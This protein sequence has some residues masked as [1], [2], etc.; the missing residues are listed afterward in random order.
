[1]ETFKVI[2]HTDGDDKC[3]RN[4]VNYPIGIDDSDLLLVVGDIAKNCYGAGY[5]QS[6]NISVEILYIDNFRG[7]I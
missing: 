2:L 1:M 6:H 5:A 3:L 7:L 4:V